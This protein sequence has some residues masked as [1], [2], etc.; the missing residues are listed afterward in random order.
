MALAPHIHSLQSVIALPAL[1][2]FASVSV[3]LL[4]GVLV[5]RAISRIL[6]FEFLASHLRPPPSASLFS[7]V[8][9]FGWSRR[10]VPG[11]PQT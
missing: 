10:T 1:A 9:S 4:L 11:F 2:A 3:W 5:S 8:K 7:L 6:S